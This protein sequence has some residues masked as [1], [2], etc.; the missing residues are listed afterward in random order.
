MDEDL[1]AFLEKKIKKLE[2]ERLKAEV[3]HWKANHDNQVKLKQEVTRRPSRFVEMAKEIKRLKAELAAAPH[4]VPVAEFDKLNFQSI[5]FGAVP[6]YPADI[7][8]AK[9]RGGVWRASYGEVLVTDVLVGLKPP[10]KCQD[11]RGDG[12]TLPGSDVV[13]TDK[14]KKRQGTGMADLSREPSCTEQIKCSRCDGKGFVREGSDPENAVKAVYQCPKCN[15][16]KLSTECKH[17]DVRVVLGTPYDSYSHECVSCGKEVVQQDKP[18]ESPKCVDMLG[19]DVHDND[20]IWITASKQL[21]RPMTGKRSQFYA[22]C[23][24]CPRPGERIPTFKGWREMCKAMQTAGA[25][26]V[27]DEELDD[28][29]L[30]NDRIN[31]YARNSACTWRIKG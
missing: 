4:W 18:T 27:C 11:P 6:G 3:A 20:A 30:F 17:E 9:L 22:H 31:L 26:F 1:I 16:T 23:V 10:V 5:V 24:R 15:G 8:D 13:N 14:C 7:H 28:D 19:R 25:R 2:K 29:W 21:C 12:D